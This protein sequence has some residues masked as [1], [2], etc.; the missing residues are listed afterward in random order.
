MYLLFIL[1]S[2]GT[3]ELILIG[4]VA[5]IV[6]GPRKL[7]ELARKFGKTMAEFKKATSEFKDTWEREV[8]LQN[9]EAPKTIAK[10]PIQPPSS[11]NV[12]APPVI[13]EID[14]ASIPDH[15]S[16]ENRDQSESELESQEDDSAQSDKK[17]W[18]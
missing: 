18:L 10:N 17:N 8:D 3:Q 5:L 7:P 13:R 12:I 9:L 16:P 4:I 6:F 1:E 11:E 15:F 14:Q 2:I